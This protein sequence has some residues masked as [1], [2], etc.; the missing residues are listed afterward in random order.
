MPDKITY[1][2]YWHH[3]FCTAGECLRYKRPSDECVGCLYESLQKYITTKNYQDAYQYAGSTKRNL[4][5]DI[6]AVYNRWGGKDR[7]IFKGGG[8][9]R[10]NGGNGGPI[11]IS[12]EYHQ[13]NA[14]ENKTSA[15]NRRPI[16]PRKAA[17]R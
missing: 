9:S 1:A 5:R 14:P 3:V 7:N 4:E 8:N 15:D 13:A 11:R 10:C 17:R 12:F 2:E 6:Q 16:Q